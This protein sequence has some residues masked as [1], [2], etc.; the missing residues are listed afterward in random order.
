MDRGQ[1]YEALFVSLDKSIHGVILILIISHFLSNTLQIQTN[2]W[3]TDDHFEAEFS[4]FDSKFL[5]LF[6]DCLIPIIDGQCLL[7]SV[8]YLFG[9]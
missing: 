8:C 9:Q 3:I 1:Y 5:H 7:Y 2:G 4:H 6:G